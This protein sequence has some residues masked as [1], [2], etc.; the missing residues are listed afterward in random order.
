MGGRIERVG[1][2]R[3][4]IIEILATDRTIDI[5]KQGSIA[6]KFSNILA[7]SASFDSEALQDE[8]N[9]GEHASVQWICEEPVS[10]I[11]TV[12]HNNNNYNSIDMFKIKS[13]S[14]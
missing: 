3:V 12:A 5:A 1:Q 2:T 13:F 11:G 8:V 10:I 6:R 9:P 4:P 7:A 14:H